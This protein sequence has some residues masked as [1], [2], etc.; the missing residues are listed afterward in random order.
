MTAHALP[1]PTPK[2][3]TLWTI[4]V[5]AVL[6]LWSVVCVFPIYWLAVTSIKS[7]AVI[8][9][10]P[11]YIPFVDFMPSLDAWRFV[12]GDQRETL[13]PRFINSLV[14]GVFSTVITLVAACLAIY[15][16][17]RLRLVP[18][19]PSLAAV[20]FAATAFAAVPLSSGVMRWVLAALGMTL[21][22]L[23]IVLRHSGPLLGR[24]S[25]MGF[26]L[27]T[28]ILPPVI[29]VLPL[30][31]MAQATGLRDTRTAMVLVYTAVNLPVAVWLLQPVL[32]SRTTEQ[33]EAALLEGA[34]HATILFTILLPM[35]RAGVAATALLVFLLCWNE[36]LFAAYLTADTALTLPPWMVGQLSIKE[37]QV[38][39]EPE[40][41]AH[42]SA[43]AIFMAVPPLL[44]AG[45]IQRLLARTLVAGRMLR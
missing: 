44:L 20:V 24:F 30:Y 11:T 34:T 27:A 43:A 13:V 39:G 40:E 8:D 37:A 31:L 5:Y 3:F 6:A 9:G 2:P 33:E 7:I 10:P 29:L 25:L 12:L 28:R 18:R 22:G 26:T 21:L 32:G 35:V 42:L 17:T 15:G 23:S 1:A 4:V 41:W 36:Y 16:L 45:F 38:G 19:L 14:I